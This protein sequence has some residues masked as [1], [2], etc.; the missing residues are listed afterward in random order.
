LKY[1]ATKKP[2]STI[3]VASQVE[4]VDQSSPLNTST[5]DNQPIIDKGMG[6][7]DHQTP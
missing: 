3:Y 2:F 4:G 5:Y 6:G 1:F 7:S